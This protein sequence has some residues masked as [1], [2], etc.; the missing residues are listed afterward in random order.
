MNRRNGYATL[1][2]MKLSIF[3]ITEDVM[4]DPTK[5]I[6]L[7]TRRVIQAGNNLRGIETDILKFHVLCVI[8]NID[9][10]AYFIDHFR[11]E[12][13][14]RAVEFLLNSHLPVGLQ[15][16]GCGG[17]FMTP[18]LCASLWN[19]SRDIIR[20]LYANGASLHLADCDGRYPEEKLSTIPYFDHLISGNCDPNNNRMIYRRDVTE[21]SDALSEI[22]YIVGE[23]APPASWPMPSRLIASG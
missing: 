22:R 14:Q 15:V 1:S 6:E 18:I 10:L 5:H 8:G 17:F 12:N 11:S 19:N 23:E 2:Q 16:R 7:M 4:E 9:A 20:L 21:F 13:G 3:G